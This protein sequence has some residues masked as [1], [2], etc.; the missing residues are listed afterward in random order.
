MFLLVINIGISECSK[1]LKKMSHDVNEFK[2]FSFAF[3][4]KMN[5]IQSLESHL[6]NVN[7]PLKKTK[8][9]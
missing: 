3:W 7:A 5:N 4:N 2:S 6:W 8:S 9:N 1:G